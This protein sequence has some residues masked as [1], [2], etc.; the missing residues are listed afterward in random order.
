MI[1]LKN[2]SKT[3]QRNISSITVI[4]ALELGRG[5]GSLAV[6]ASG[7]RDGSGSVEIT[8]Q[9]STVLTIPYCVHEQHIK[10]CVL[11]SLLSSEF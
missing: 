7:V 10:P 4:Q 8:S 9:V 3:S 5:R 6:L 1:L 11:K 2:C